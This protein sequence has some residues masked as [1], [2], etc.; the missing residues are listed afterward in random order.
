MNSQPIERDSKLPLN[1]WAHMA[2]LVQPSQRAAAAGLRNRKHNNNHQFGWMDVWRAADSIPTIPALPF[3]SFRAT[4]ECF[5]LPHTR[6]IKLLQ[7]RIERGWMKT[8]LEHGIIIIINHIHSIHY[9][10]IRM[11]ATIQSSVRPSATT[12]EQH[13]FRVIP[14]S[15][16][17]FFFLTPQLKHNVIQSVQPEERQEKGVEN[18]AP[19]D[20]EN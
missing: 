4:T 15:S 13:C 1:N 2:S 5:L 8:V 18:W 10:F 19:D 20:E 6:C 17:F 12:T 16:F 11:M 14:N 3:F 9:Y 7:R